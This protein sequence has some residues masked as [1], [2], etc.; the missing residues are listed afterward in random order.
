[1]REILLI[2]SALVIYDIIK[3]LW[4][5]WIADRQ[6]KEQKKRIRDSDLNRPGE[7]KSKFQQR[8]EDALEVNKRVKKYEK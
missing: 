8:L 4:F 2:I 5:F 1:M 7:P 6:E 3:W